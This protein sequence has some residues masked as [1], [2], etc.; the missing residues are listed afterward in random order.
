MYNM[1][2]EFP[3]GVECEEV[4]WQCTFF[5]SSLN[6]NAFMFC[7]FHSNG[8]WWRSMM[9]WWHDEC[10]GGGQNQNVGLEYKPGTV[11]SR[12]L[13]ERFMRWRTMR[14]RCITMKR[15]AFSHQ[16][17]GCFTSSLNA[18]CFTQRS[19]LLGSWLE[20]KLAPKK[21]E[22]KKP[23]VAFY[24][25]HVKAS[26][27]QWSTVRWRLTWTQLPALTPKKTS[28]REEKLCSIFS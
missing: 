1:S 28:W 11:P 5:Y 14:L 24:S 21:K 19:A 7:E 23:L 6:N 12:V 25:F 8:Q 9:E 17:T 22:K 20:K 13:V 4:R 26:E 2:C 10:A 15:S 18:M 16:C 3:T 27:R